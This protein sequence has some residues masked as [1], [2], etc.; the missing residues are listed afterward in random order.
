MTKN[1]WDYSEASLMRYAS[2]ALL[3]IKI[4]AGSKGAGEEASCEI[5]GL[6][7]PGK[8]GKGAGGEASCEIRG[9]W[10]PGTSDKGAGGVT[11]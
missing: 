9:L 11:S 6:W 1:I 2:E 10:S 4:D 7:S 8:R 5:R 3:A